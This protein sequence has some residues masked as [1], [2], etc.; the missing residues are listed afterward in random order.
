MNKLR[1]VTVAVACAILATTLLVSG[2]ESVQ[3]GK[4]WA[5][6]EKGTGRY[7][8][9]TNLL[10]LSEEEMGEVENLLPRVEIKEPTGNAQVEVKDVGMV[11]A[12]CPI[13]GLQPNTLV[14]VKQLA[15][16]TWVVLGVRK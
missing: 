13:Q 5:Y 10:G 6:E 8:E 14:D 16:G 12:K 3:L 11:I 2:C 1:L 9:P 15:D 7:K 4:F